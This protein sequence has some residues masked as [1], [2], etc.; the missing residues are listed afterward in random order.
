V[1]WTELLIKNVRNVLIFN[2]A[3]LFKSLVFHC[4]VL[5]VVSGICDLWCCVTA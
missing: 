4:I 1:V 2:R 3:E 5:F